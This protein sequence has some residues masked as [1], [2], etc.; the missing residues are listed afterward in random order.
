MLT[1][2][3]LKSLKPRDKAYKVSDRDGMYVTVSPAGTVA[4]RYDY[5]LNGRRET[6]TIGRYDPTLKE[7]RQPSELAYGMSLSLAE[8]RALLLDARR[9]VEAGVS[10]SRAKV[11]K[12]TEAAASP[13]FGAWTQKYFE[14]KADP[15]SGEERLAESTLAMR[16]SIYKRALEAKFGKLKLEE[17]SAARLKALCDDLKQNRG[18]AVAV[19]T[20]DLVLNVFRYAQ[21]SGVAV[22]NPAEAVRPNTIA[23]FKPRDRALDPSEIRQFFAAL[24]RVAT[25]PTLRLAVKFV[26][27]TGVRK[28]EFIDATWDE[29]DFEGAKWVIPASRMKAGKEHVVFLCEQALDILTALRACFGASR[30]LHPGR[31]DSEVPISNATLNRVIDAAVQVVRKDDP[32]F[33]SFGVHDLRRTFSTGL[34]RAKFDERWIEMALAHAPRNEI[35]ATYNVARYTA[36]RRIMMQCWADMI[37]CWVRGESARDLILAAKKQAAEVLDLEIDEDM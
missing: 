17:I 6:L 12:R 26:L 33:E 31:Y 35:A 3:E 1:N 30:Y 32:D 36:E 7:T 18:P 25:T 28:S 11:E 29:V 23:T 34:N 21:G 4:F 5:R 24:E 16:K 8:A 15:K 37:D 9:S 20:R 22:L 13:T 10:P 2:I 19:Q 27:L 14:F